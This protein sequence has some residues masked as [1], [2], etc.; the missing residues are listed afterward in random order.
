M[1]EHARISATKRSIAKALEKGEV[2]GKKLFETVNSEIGSGKTIFG[3]ALNQMLGAD[4]VK[5]RR[6]PGSIR[7]R[8]YTLLKDG[9]KWLTQQ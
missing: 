6:K 8:L 7:G 4:E 9:H 3:A 2:D 1:S 5:E